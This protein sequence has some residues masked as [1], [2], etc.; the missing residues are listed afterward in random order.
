V[1]PSRLPRPFSPEELRRLYV[2]NASRPDVLAACSFLRATGLRSAEALSIT[3]DEASSWLPPR[4][5]RR[6][7]PPMT[8]IVGKGDKERVCVLSRSA[9]AAAHELLAFAPS[10]GRAGLMMPWC[11]RSLRYVLAAAGDRAGV[12]NVHPH[13]FRRQFAFD[14]IEAGVAIE[15]VADMMG[16][17]STD[18]TRIYYTA[19]ISRQREALRIRERGRRRPS[20]GLGF[21]R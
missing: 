5:F 10:A 11:A 9:V 7:T 15:L 17:R 13:R 12:A 3:A 18:T 14:L 20:V 6:F 16:H 2:A 4:R 19:S 1:N 8:R 21:G